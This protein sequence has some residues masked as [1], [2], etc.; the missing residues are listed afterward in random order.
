M[1]ECDIQRMK[2]K[3]KQKKIKKEKK[4]EIDEQLLVSN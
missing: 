2:K 3:I 4:K 1:R